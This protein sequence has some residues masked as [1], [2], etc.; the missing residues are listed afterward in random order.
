MNHI[1]YLEAFLI[2]NAQVQQKV[3]LSVG[4]KPFFEVNSELLYEI[5][6]VIT[7]KRMQDRSI[8]SSL[9]PKFDNRFFVDL[10]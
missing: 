8:D 6:P 10:L 4:D 3:L 7:V 1:L 2:L 5:K 9:K